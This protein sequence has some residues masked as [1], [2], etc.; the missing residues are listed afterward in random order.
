MST[1]VTTFNNNYI[2][3]TVWRE[4]DG[5]YCI[6][7]QRWPNGNATRELSNGHF[8]DAESNE[9]SQ[10]F[11]DKAKAIKYAEAEFDSAEG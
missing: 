4:D 7:T 11:W 1:Q 8:P 6:Q 5:R 3:V 9:F 2:D 10:H